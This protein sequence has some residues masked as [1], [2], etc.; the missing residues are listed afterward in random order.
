[1]VG[2]C[3]AVSAMASMLKATLTEDHR[4]VTL[5]L[6]G[7]LCGP[8]AAEAEHSWRD[9]LVRSGTNT[10]LVDLSGVSFVDGGGELLLTDMLEHG[11]SLR[12]EGVLMNHLLDDLRG[13]VKQSHEEEFSRRAPRSHRDP[14]V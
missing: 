10:V 14:G 12:V 2:P 1:M 9:A 5:V 13:R 11:A 6:E 3:D 4:R 7:R 8:C